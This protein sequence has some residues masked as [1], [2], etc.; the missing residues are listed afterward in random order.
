ML[1]P[2]LLGL[3]RAWAPRIMLP[4]SLFIGYVGETK[5]LLGEEAHSCSKSWSLRQFYALL[6]LSLT[7]FYGDAGEISRKFFGSKTPGE[8]EQI[9]T[10]LVCF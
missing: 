3:A 6:R 1:N 10:E 7:N 9:T 4:F 5:D 8:R 2:W